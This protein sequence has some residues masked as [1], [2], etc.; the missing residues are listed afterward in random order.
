RQA[1]A[2]GGSGRVAFPSFHRMGEMPMDPSKLSGMLALASSEMPTCQSLLRYCGLYALES[3]SR[4]NCVDGIEP[5]SMNTTCAPLLRICCTSTGI[6]EDAVP[7]S[8]DRF[9]TWTTSRPS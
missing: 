9:E 5:V 1:V 3:A 4:T 8:L 6:W 2:E 7:W